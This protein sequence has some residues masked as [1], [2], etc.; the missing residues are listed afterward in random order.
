MTKR[1]KRRMERK[2][3]QHLISN[4]LEVYNILRY[5]NDNKIQ[6]IADNDKVWGYQLPVWRMIE[7]AGCPKST[8]SS[9]HIITTVRL[10]NSLRE[11]TM[12]HRF[13]SS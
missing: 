8:K 13:S 9:P 2:A 1:V 3:S 6:Y 5:R 7:L 11:G 12:F 4:F 10:S